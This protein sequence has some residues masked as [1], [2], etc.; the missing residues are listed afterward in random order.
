MQ[1]GARNAN[2]NRERQKS[3]SA[4]KTGTP[5]LAYPLLVHTRRIR[6]HGEEVCQTLSQLLILG[7]VGREIG[8]YET[9]QDLVCASY[10]RVVRKHHPDILDG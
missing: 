9:L 4:Q 2:Q 5:Y 6:I 10:K 7:R 8:H 1:M 3:K